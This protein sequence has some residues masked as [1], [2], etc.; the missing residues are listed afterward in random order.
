LGNRWG[1][2]GNQHQYTWRSAIGSDVA[3]NL[4]YVAGDQL[5]LATLARALGATGAVRGMALDIH[6]NMVHL[7]TYRHDAVAAEPIPSKLLDTMRGPSD[8]YLT[9]DRRDFFAITER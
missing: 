2:A 5:T 3:G 6:P 9:P 1:S 4:Y 7:F 8:R